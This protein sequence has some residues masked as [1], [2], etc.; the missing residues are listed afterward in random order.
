M[1]GTTRVTDK[2]KNTWE[3]W[4]ATLIIGERKSAKLYFKKYPD[5]SHHQ[6]QFGK[7]L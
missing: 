6:G 4:H 2:N 5:G 7:Y 1:I 3:T